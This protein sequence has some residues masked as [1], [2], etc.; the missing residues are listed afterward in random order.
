MK[1]VSLETLRSCGQ[2][3]EHST[4]GNIVRN[5]TC[6]VCGGYYTCTSDFKLHFT[7]EFHKKLSLIHI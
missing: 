1:L 3:V 5:M 6:S 7:G 4:P 2:V